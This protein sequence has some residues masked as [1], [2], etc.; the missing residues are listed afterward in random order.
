VSD[1]ALVELRCS[2]IVFS[3]EAVLLLDRRRNGTGL[4]PARRPSPATGGH[5]VPAA[6]SD[7]EMSTSSGASS[8]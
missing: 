1:R 3:G 6:P 5:H 2:A 4:G 7:P 8:R